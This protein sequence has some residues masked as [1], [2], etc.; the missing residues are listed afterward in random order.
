[1][2]LEANLHASERKK[3]PRYVC[4]Y[5]LHFRS[6]PLHFREGKKTFAMAFASLDT[7]FFTRSLAFFLVHFQGCFQKRL[8]LDTRIWFYCIVLQFQ[9]LHC[10]ARGMGWF[11]AVWKDLS[12]MHFLAGVW[13][14]Q[15]G[16]HD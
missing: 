7:P 9:R 3:N 16:V 14:G 2:L 1:M 13:I 10:T 6:I 4:V 15:V 11:S 12:H 8:S 5:T